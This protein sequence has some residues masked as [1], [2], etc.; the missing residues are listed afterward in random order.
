MSDKL[1]EIDDSQFEEIVLQNSKP[2]V[3]DFWAP[4]CGP[5]RMFTPIIED[6]ANEVNSVDFVK[7]NIDE[8]RDFAAKFRVRN[9][10]AILIFK[11]GEV[12]AKQEGAL[13]K[14]KFIDFINQSIN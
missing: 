9:I 1:K 3:V 14:Q 8:S 12:I 6:V 4:W 2:V 5:C 10:P 11:N 13:N 7:V